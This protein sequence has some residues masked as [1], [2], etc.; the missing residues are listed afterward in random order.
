M[1]KIC[2]MLLAVFLLFGVS[3]AAGRP[4]RADITPSERQ[5]EQWTEKLSEFVRDVRFNEEDMQSFIRLY[6][7]FSAIGGDQHD[8]GEEEYVDFNAVLQDPEY[9]SWAGSKGLDSDM[10]LKKTMRII[11]IMMRT[12]M[13]ADNSAVRFDMQAQLEELEKMKDHMGEEV[14]RQMKQAMTEGSVAMQN[15]EDSSRNLPVPTGTEKALLAKYNDQ[16]MNLE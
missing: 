3:P 8:S 4:G 2:L 11:A 1:K 12:E 16:I 5:F 14:Y 7:E 15:M 13:A 6:P 10:W 9:R